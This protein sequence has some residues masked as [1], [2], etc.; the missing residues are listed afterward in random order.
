MAGHIATA[1][2]ADWC[3]PIHLIQAVENVFGGAIDLDPCYNA[4]GCIFPKKAYDITKGENGLKLPWK[5]N[6]FVNPPYGTTYLDPVT[7]KCFSKARTSDMVNLLPEVAARFTKQSLLD[8]IKKCVAENTHA[9][10]IALIPA[11]VDT[12]VWQGQVFHWASKICFL[13][14]RVPFV[15]DKGNSGP[16]PMA[17]AMVLFSF[18]AEIED[19]FEETFSKLGFVI[20][21]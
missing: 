4:K 9:N 17:C 18:N 8:W 5:G 1:G 6:V 3:T 14:G 12:K 11:N 7:N 10:V 13:K 2:K 21:V 20:S 16:A 19:R 15:D